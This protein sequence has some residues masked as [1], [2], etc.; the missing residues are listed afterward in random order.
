VGSAKVRYA[1]RSLD[2]H[3]YAEQ[4]DDELDLLEG[5]LLIAKDAYPGLDPVLVEA[6]LDALADPLV[7]ARVAEMPA[8]IQARA[9]QEHLFVRLGFRGNRDDYYD[10]KNSF[11]N[12]VVARRM[13][14]PIS[15]SLVYVEVARRAGVVAS[16]V[17]FPGHFLARI[18][19]H[20][21]RVVI[22]PFHGGESLDVVALA[23][24]LRR[25][26]SKLRYSADM[27]AATPVRHVVARMLMNLRGIYA[28][29][30]EYARLL[31][32]LDRLIDILP[33]ASEELRDR[34]LLLGRLGAPEA[35]ARDLDT[36]VER[37]PHA[38]DV[39]EVRRWIERFRASSRG[40]TS[41]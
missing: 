37:Q 1:S 29:R 25:A 32:V 28:S 14:I 12:E 35:A 22:D 20:D 5:A 13:G 19:D 41:N 2:F 26:G 8:P 11:L 34:G 9:L 16:P 36:Y 15:L 10:P 40:S 33:D 39:P 6:D 24:L 38:S 3:A 30:G 31:V 23:E 7:K 17:G 18:D 4:P 27:I 21:R